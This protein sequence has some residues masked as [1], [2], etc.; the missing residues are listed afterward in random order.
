MFLDYIAYL[1]INEHDK[2][3]HYFNDMYNLMHHR[4]E[5]PR[6]CFEVVTPVLL[7]H[8]I[9]PPSSS[10][11]SSSSSLAFP[12]SPGLPQS[13]GSR[14]PQQS[15]FRNVP[16]CEDILT[17]NVL[18]EEDLRVFQLTEKSQEFKHSWL[19]DEITGEHAGRS[20]GL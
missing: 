7:L 1:K 6:Y 3:I 5:E 19:H 4:S 14:Q 18:P 10:S 15:S 17:G 9:Q 13:V 20:M 16:A 2:N 12:S 11:F 8:L